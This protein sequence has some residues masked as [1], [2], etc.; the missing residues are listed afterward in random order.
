[1][2]NRSAGRNHRDKYLISDILSRNRDDVIDF[3]RSFFIHTWYEYLSENLNKTEIRNLEKNVTFPIYRS[4]IH[5]R[6]CKSAWNCIKAEWRKNS[7]INENLIQIIF[8]TVKNYI[9]AYFNPISIPVIQLLYFS[10]DDLSTPVK[11]SSSPSLIDA[12]PFILRY[13]WTTINAVSIKCSRR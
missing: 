2:K 7:T 13:R 9:F 10:I 4:K 1:M 8:I 12:V 5:F 3:S 11:N 6:K